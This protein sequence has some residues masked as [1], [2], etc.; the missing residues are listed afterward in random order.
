MKI[1]GI[2]KIFS[3]ALRASLAFFLL[4]LFTLGMSN[5]SLALGLTSASI[6][7]GGRL[8][9]NQVYS[10]M[11]AGGKNLS[12]QLA[13]SDLPVTA[14][15]LA[16]TIYDPDAPT[17]S[18]WW[19]WVVFNIPVDT[20]EL[21]EG[22]SQT[23]AMP[24]GAIES[25]TDFGTPGFGGA[26]PPPGDK[27]HHYIVTLWVLDVEKLDLNEKTPAAQVGFYLKKHEIEKAYITGLYSR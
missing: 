7:N 11:G 22:A 1:F 6:R 21:R 24:K 10:G 25:M 15:S 13:W 27:P 20:T 5:K 18:G 4:M 16:I 8:A 14:K 3:R 2:I 12:P 26:A 23:A 19:H 9:I 17:G